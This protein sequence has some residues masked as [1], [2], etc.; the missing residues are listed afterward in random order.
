MLLADPNHDCIWVGMLV[1]NERKLLTQIKAC[2]V[3]F[4]SFYQNKKYAYYKLYLGLLP[5]FLYFVAKI[6]SLFP[7]SSKKK[8]KKIRGK[9]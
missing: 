6:F 5:I 1:K 9:H 4:D 7:N 8:K 2:L 3:H